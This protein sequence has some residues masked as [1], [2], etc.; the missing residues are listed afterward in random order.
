VKIVL[1]LLQEQPVIVHIGGPPD[2][3]AASVR[4]LTR[5]I[6]G[7]LGL[8]GAFAVLALAMGVLIGG[9]LYWRFSRVGARPSRPLS[10]TSDTSVSR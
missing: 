3:D 2:K 9:V 4:E 10:T 7:S 5:I 8:T 1:A 6:V